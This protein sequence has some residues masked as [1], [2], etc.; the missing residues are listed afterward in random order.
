[1]DFDTGAI[2]W[3]KPGEDPKSMS[4][5][6]AAL[7][8][9]GLFYVTS[10]V[11]SRWPFKV[12][13][14]RITA[15]ELQSGNVRWTRDFE[16]PL[17]ANAAPTVFHAGKGGPLMV[18][19]GLGPN[20]GFPYPAP[21]TMNWYDNPGLFVAVNAETGETVW[22]FEPPKW[23]GRNSRGSTIFDINLPDSWTNAAADV[24]G[25][26]YVMFHSGIVYALDGATGREVSQ[27]D[28][29]SAGQGCPAIGPGMLVVAAGKRVAA[30][31][32]ET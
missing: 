4:T 18:G 29:E 12:S 23:C 27:Y 28:M 14:G 3:K 20:C 7:G 11:G 6:G 16:K 8:Q 32:H 25:T 15:Y 19:T 1:L 22:T 5:G 2:R 31:L 26:L 9:N 30:F 24:D 21:V 13:S 17:E 10:N